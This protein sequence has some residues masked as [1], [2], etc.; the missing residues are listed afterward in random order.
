MLVADA[1]W[2][3]FGP[4]SNVRMILSSEKAGTPFEELYFLRASLPF[5]AISYGCINISKGVIADPTY[6]VVLKIYKG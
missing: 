3:P 4:S 5:P 1:S 2:M 6:M